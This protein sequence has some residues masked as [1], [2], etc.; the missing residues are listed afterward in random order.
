MG[1]NVKSAKS[2]PFFLGTTER[3]RDG[4]LGVAVP[5]L[6]C[7]VELFRVDCLPITARTSSSATTRFA[8]RYRR[9]A[10]TTSEHSV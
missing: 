5:G 7:R 8:T 2:S 1:R 3:E 9:S 4:D 6:P 10:V